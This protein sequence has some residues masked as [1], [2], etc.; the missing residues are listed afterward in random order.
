MVPITLL[1][2]I[3]AHEVTT[4]T[5]IDYPDPHTPEV[6]VLI[7]ERT[8]AA[9]DLLATLPMMQRLVMAWKTDGFSYEEI[10]KE[11]RTTPG[12]V[13]Q[14]MHRARSAL[15]RQLAASSEGGEG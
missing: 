9:R 1:N 2:S 11:L 4:D 10:A 3:P 14:N 13:R 7:S 8:Q 6:E 5:P 12:A 15:K